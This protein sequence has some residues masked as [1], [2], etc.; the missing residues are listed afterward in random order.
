MVEIAGGRSETLLVRVARRLRS[1]LE[2]FRPSELLWQHRK[3]KRDRAFDAVHNVNTA[4]VLLPGKFGVARED[5]RGSVMY[6]SVEP[7]EFHRALSALDID[8][9]R[10][11]FVDFGSGKG[12]ALLLASSYPF[13]KIVGVELSPVLHAVAE[14]NVRSFRSVAQRCSAFELHNVNALQFELPAAPLVLFLYNPFGPEILAQLA[15]RIRE[16]YEQAPRDIYVVYVNPVFADVWHRS[17]LPE[18]RRGD[19]YAIFRLPEPNH[20]SRGTRDASL[21]AAQDG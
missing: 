17:G 3:S 10:F 20:G 4:G 1:E 13:A 12:K 15:A 14:Q 18:T 19:M 6:I 7:E 16:S 8:H 11:V 2:R 21:S 5:R 9:S